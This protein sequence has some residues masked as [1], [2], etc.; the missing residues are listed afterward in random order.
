MERHRELQ[1]LRDIGEKKVDKVRVGFG[2]DKEQKKALSRLM[3]RKHRI[4]IQER[5]DT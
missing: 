2:C 3:G 1:R 4:R 5:C